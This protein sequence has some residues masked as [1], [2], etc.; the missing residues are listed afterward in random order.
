VVVLSD[1][2]RLVLELPC[3]LLIG[4]QNGIALRDL[5]SQVL[6]DVLLVGG[7]SVR[8]EGRVVVVD[9]LVVLQEGGRI[10]TRAERHKQSSNTRAW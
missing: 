3:L 6:L 9:V 10:Y 7:H 5:Q 2:D 8:D 4:S 1:F